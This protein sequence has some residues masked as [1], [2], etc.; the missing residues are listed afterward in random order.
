MKGKI[1][2]IEQEAGAEADDILEWG[3]QISYGQRK[4]QRAK[5]NL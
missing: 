5:K 1:R 3:K 4:I 2:R